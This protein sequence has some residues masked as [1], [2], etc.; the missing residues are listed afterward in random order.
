L[1]I[2]YW[3]VAGLLALVM[4]AAGGMKAIKP[5]ADI[6]K[7]GMA[8]AEDFAPGMIKFIGVAEVLGAVGLVL[9][10]LT[11]IAPV[12]APIA[13]VALAVVMIGA[14]VVHARRKE[15]FSGAL[16]LALV[17]VAAAVLGFLA[18]A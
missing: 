11:G 3:I 16:V 7:G 2:A 6:V 10:A 4:L 8:W 17:A 5:K 18:V 9:P 14:V 15:A 1:L 12:L 13:A